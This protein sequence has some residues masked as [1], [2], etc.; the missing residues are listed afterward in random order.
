MNGKTCRYVSQVPAEKRKMERCAAKFRGRRCSARDS[1]TE[2]GEVEKDEKATGEG[3]AHPR[4]SPF[5]FSAAALSSDFSILAM[6]RPHTAVR[7]RVGF[8]LQ[9]VEVIVDGW[10]PGDGGVDGLQ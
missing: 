8:R 5:L 1:G 2:G 10:D 6:N 9:V 7:A 3:G 4:H